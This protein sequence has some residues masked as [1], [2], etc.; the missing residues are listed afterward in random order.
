MNM[1]GVPTTVR[2]RTTMRGEEE[3]RGAREAVG[4]R[5]PVVWRRRCAHETSVGS[6][7]VP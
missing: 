6:D 4:E 1:A 2:G 5:K 7:V 3:R